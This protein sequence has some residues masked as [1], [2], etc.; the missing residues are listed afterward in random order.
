[1]MRGSKNRANVRRVPIGLSVGAVTLVVLISEL[2]LFAADV[3]IVQG[4]GI[5][6]GAN[7][8]QP[9]TPPAAGYTAASA[10]SSNPQ[11]VQTRGVDLNGGIWGV[12]FT[13]TGLG[14]GVITVAWTNLATSSVRRRYFVVAS[15]VRVNSASTIV[16]TVGDTVTVPAPNALTADAYAGDNTSS[17]QTVAAAVRE[18]GVQITGQGKGTSFIYVQ[19]PR[20]QSG[21][22]HYQVAI[23]TV[24]APGEPETVD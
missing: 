9:V 5:A 22:A 20:D 14:I 8:R 10:T 18:D 16:L 7:R 13:V 21:T 24:L 12:N 23:V 17:S 15:G 11:V 6:V 1:M 2:P 19:L 4:S 3:A